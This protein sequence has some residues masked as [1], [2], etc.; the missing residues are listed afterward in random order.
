MDI[1]QAEET[2]FSI[3][4]KANCGKSIKL[5]IKA[6]FRKYDSIQLS[7]LRKGYKNIIN[8]LAKGHRCRKKGFAIYFKHTFQRMNKFR[9]IY[10]G[11][12]TNSFQSS[13]ASTNL[14]KTYS[15][16]LKNVLLDVFL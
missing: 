13:Q 8:I 7:K 1:G 15:F 14:I 6:A 11:H 3:I 2:L 10:P 9:S 12:P 4:Q 5:S 16:H